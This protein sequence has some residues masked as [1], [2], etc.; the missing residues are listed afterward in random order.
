MTSIDEQGVVYTARTCVAPLDDLPPS[1]APD[2]LR[3]RAVCVAEYTI[4]NTR[5]ADADAILIFSV[6]KKNRADQDEEQELPL[7]PVDGGAIASLDG[8]LLAF[9]DA[10]GAAPLEVKTDSQTAMV[11]GRLPA[12]GKARVAA[13]LPAWKVAPDQYAMFREQAP[14][15]VTKVKQYWE[16]LFAPAARIEL[17][18]ELLTNVIR[19]S[20]VHIMLAAG[21]EE[22]GTRVDPWTSADRYGALESE[23]QPILRGMDMM[24]QQEFARR[25]LDFFVARY[26]EAGFLTTGY[27]IMGSGWHLWT[28]AEFVDRS[29]DLDW[30]RAVARGRPH[31]PLDRPPARED[32]ASRR[33]GREGSELRTDAAG[34]HRRLGAVYEYRVPGG[35][36]LHR[37]ARSGLGAGQDRP[38]RRE[39]PGPER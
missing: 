36:L 25:G 4:E 28:L 12:G 16:R 29:Q 8:R 34:H 15:W 7:R 26:N 37:A 39:G 13:Y 9:I 35:P 27:T 23:S 33:A 24:G 38:S 20:Q 6:L 18:D 3:Q 19:A 2:W 5:A 1:G 14:E 30:F 31:V 10:A 32:Q 22:N 21:S 11:V 17:P